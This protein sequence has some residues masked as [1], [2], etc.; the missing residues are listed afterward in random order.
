MKYYKLHQGL[1]WKKET[2]Q[3]ISTEKKEYKSLVRKVRRECCSN[4]ERACAE[5]S[6][7]LLGW[8]EIGVIRP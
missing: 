5:N 1:V 3:G 7:H 2:I 6:Y 4:S 8:E